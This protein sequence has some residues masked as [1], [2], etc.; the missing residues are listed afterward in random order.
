MKSANEEFERLL[1]EDVNE[2]LSKCKECGVCL[3]KK[4]TH[5]HFKSSH[6]PGRNLITD[7]FPGPSFR[8]L[9]C[10]IEEKGRKLDLRRAHCMTEHPLELMKAMKS[11]PSSNNPSRLLQKRLNDIQIDRQKEKIPE[12]FNKYE[13]VDNLF[14]SHMH[15]HPPKNKLEGGD[16]TSGLRKTSVLKP[17][18]QTPDLKTTSSNGVKLKACPGEELVSNEKDTDKNSVDPNIEI[19]RPKY[20]GLPVLDYQKCREIFQKSIAAQFIFKRISLDI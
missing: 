15:D 9:F 4:L 8:C 2:T 11:V 13:Q 10:G 6:Y 5:S 14:K 1:F 20:N 17:A 12:D 3:G 16:E 7:I 19:Q 18:V